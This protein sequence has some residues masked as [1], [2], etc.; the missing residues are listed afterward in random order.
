MMANATHARSTGDARQRPPAAEGPTDR[1]LLERFVHWNDESAFAALVA[2]HG[3]MVLG[4]CRR[5][6]RHTQEAE[7]AFQATFLILARKAG[8]LKEPDLLANWLYGVAS[9]T[10]RKAHAGVVRRIQVERLAPVAA[11]PPEEEADNADLLARLDEE[12]A[13]LPTQY[14]AP[15]VL[16]YLE[17]LTNEEAARRLGWPAGSI[18]YRLARAREILRQRL[19]RRGTAPAAFALLLRDGLAPGDLPAGLGEQTVE[20]AM[21]LARGLDLAAVASPAVGRLVR[22]AAGPRR[23]RTVLLLL[24]AALLGLLAAGTL[25]AA[26]AWGPPKGPNAAGSCH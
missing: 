23:R 9:R 8:A 19:S 15:L 13:G 6:L 16:C 24:G 14:R 4:V 7:D 26:G 20:T 2:R 5:V 17:G 25:A 12:L 22:A 11:R 3:P 1:A 18:S 10:A 21:G